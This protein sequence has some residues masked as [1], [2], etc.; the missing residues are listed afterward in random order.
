MF[1]KTKAFWT[2][3]VWVVGRTYT[4]EVKFVVSYVFSDKDVNLPQQLEFKLQIH[5]E[6]IATEDGARG[7]L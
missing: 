4:T 5:S 2:V 1:R 7:C 3:S 6:H